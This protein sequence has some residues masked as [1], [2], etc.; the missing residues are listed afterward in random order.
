MMEDRDKF[1]VDYVVNMTLASIFILSGIILTGFLLRNSLLFE[2]PFDNPAVFVISILLVLILEFDSLLAGFVPASTGFLTY[3]LCSKL[4]KEY[5]ENG[6][7]STEKYKKLITFS[8]IS[9]FTAPL[10]LFGSI[11]LVIFSDK[12]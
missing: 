7:V 5:S 10:I 1:R 11:A 4:K 9:T 6:S 12:I 8:Y 3:Y 2:M